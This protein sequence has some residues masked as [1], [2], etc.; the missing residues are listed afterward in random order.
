[1]VTERD[2]AAPRATA[3]VLAAA[4]DIALVVIF[5]VIGRAS[6]DEGP[7][8]LLVTAWPFLGGLAIGWL[9]MRAWRHPRRIVW[10]GIGIWIATLAGGMLLRVISGQGTAIAFIVVATVA[11]GVV[12]I[13]WRAIARLVLRNR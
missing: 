2:P 9:L 3:V 4:I 12:L 10:T 6:H 13:G 7:A 1:M 8:G 5:T 11:L